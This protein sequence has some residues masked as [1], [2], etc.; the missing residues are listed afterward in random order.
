MIETILKD[1]ER[2]YGLRYSCL[3][4]FNVAGG[5]PEGKIRNHQLKENNLIPIALRSLQQA[6]GSITIFYPLK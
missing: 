3:R 1:L 6:N 5:D 4:Y 2:A